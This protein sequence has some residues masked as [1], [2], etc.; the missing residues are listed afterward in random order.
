[1]ND[2][3]IQVDAISKRYRLGVVG[4]GTLLQIQALWERNRMSCGW[5]AREDFVPQTPAEGACCLGWL[6]KHGNRETYISA[7]KLE[8]C[9]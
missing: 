8:K 6:K 5:F 1:M 4:T 3:V 9:L 2:T 7:R